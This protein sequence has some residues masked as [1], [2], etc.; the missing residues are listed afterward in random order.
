MDSI[1]SII[2]RAVPRVGASNT[3]VWLNTVP[4]SL[5]VFMG[6]RFSPILVPGAGLEPAR[7]FS[8]WILSPPRLP[9]RHPG[10]AINYT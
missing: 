9:F 8:Q 2:L 5:A 6:K 1:C 3:P 7:D 10:T 4:V